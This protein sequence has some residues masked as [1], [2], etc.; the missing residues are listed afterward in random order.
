MNRN[1]HPLKKSIKLFCPVFNCSKKKRIYNRTIILHFIYFI[2]L[3]EVYDVQRF[4][5]D[6]DD[7]D[8]DDDMI[9]KVLL[10]TFI[11]P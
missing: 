11:A 4:D 8:D 6:V 10:F 2:A 5:V 1:S 9:F 3:L 7:D